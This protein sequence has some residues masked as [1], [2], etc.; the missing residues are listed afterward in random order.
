MLVSALRVFEVVLQ[1]LLVLDRDGPTCCQ[2]SSGW[3]Y[4]NFLDRRVHSTIRT[5]E[6]LPPNAAVVE[7]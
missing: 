4:M 7:R 3:G 6:S 5:A 1:G 2:T